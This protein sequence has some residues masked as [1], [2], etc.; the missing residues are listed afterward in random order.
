M[1]DA[2]RSGDCV[3]PPTFFG[4]GMGG[5]FCCD[6]GSLVRDEAG[7]DET[8]SAIRVFPNISVLTLNLDGSKGA[9]VSEKTKA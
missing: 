9:G 8:G 2:A 1:G 6:S 4:Q 7:N 3:L 5:L